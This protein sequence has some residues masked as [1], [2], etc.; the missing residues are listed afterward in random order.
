MAVFATEL[1]G[2]G[3]FGWRVVFHRLWVFAFMMWYGYFFKL[4]DLGVLGVRCLVF[5][6]GLY[7][8]CEEIGSEVS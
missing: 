3:W 1:C 8:G 7:H 4:I 6:H 2:V 5:A